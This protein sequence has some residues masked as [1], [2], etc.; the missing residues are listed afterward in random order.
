[1]CTLPYEPQSIGIGYMYMYILFSMCLFT[2]DQIYQTLYVYSVEYVFPICLV[3][4]HAHDHMYHT[5]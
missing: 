1:M 2:H 4:H 5:L 3:T